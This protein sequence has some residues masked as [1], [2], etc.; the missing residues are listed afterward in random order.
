MKGEHDTVSWF[1]ATPSCMSV[2]SARRR[3][4]DGTNDAR[5]CYYAVFNPP[6]RRVAG[7]K[8]HEHGT[9][10]DDVSNVNVDMGCRT[11]LLPYG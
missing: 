5:G 4:P 6:L 8:E 9:P 3:G 7:R 2:S 10:R 1:P 11:V